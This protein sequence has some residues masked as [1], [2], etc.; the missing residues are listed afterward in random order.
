[1]RNIFKL[2]LIFFGTNRNINFHL[3]NACP[4]R[5]EKC[6]FFYV[7]RFPLKPITQI[8]FFALLERML[9]CKLNSLITVYL[10]FNFEG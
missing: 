1:M 9:S 4:Q 3:V 6:R 10:V 8:I 2:V 7:R 5:K